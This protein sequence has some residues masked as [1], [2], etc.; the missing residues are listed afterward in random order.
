M[1]EVL[2]ILLA[3]SIIG[4]FLFV[5]YMNHL[6]ELIDKLDTKIGTL[7]YQT[8]DALH[9]IDVVN[10]NIRNYYASLKRV[11]LNLGSLWHDASEEPQCEYEF[12]CQD[13]LGNVW[14]TDRKA[15]ETG[16]EERAIR[17]CIVRWAYV[18]DLLPKGGKQ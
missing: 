11:E 16:W 1:M 4:I 7:Q 18:K 17:E 10:K 15:N 8:D 2:I 13:T 12:I 6:N 9:D 3:I 5:V 14:L